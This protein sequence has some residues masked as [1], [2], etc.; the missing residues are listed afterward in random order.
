[1]QTKIVLALGSSALFSA[2]QGEPLP[3][4]RAVRNCNPSELPALNDGAEWDCS[5]NSCGVKCEAEG[6]FYKNQMFCNRQTE[7]EITSDI[8]ISEITCDR[9][10][11]EPKFTPECNIDRAPTAGSNGVD[12]GEWSCDKRYRRCKLVCENQHRAKTQITCNGR[13]WILRGKNTCTPPIPRTCDHSL[14]PSFGPAGSVTCSRGK[15]CSLQC[16]DHTIQGAV[17][18][19]QGEWVKRHPDMVCCDNSSKPVVPNG[20]WKC[21]DKKYTS[22]CKLQCSN[23]A[24]GRTLMRC[25]DNQWE[26]YGNGQ[27]TGKGAHPSFTVN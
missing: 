27:C 15:S 8:P 16:N 1:M 18:C 19:K 25:E 26:M 12:E 13:K 24:K 5:G 7:W 10:P 11:R 2:V 4:T 20:E 9:F 14:A 3:G 23:G 17:T 6:T 21:K 22:V